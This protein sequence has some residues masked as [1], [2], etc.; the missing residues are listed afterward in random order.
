MRYKMDIKYDVLQ[1]KYNHTRI[2]T[3]NVELRPEYV[4]GQ[5]CHTELEAKDWISKQPRGEYVIQE[6]FICHEPKNIV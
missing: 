4:M 3:R 6:V 5:R 1:L 2:N